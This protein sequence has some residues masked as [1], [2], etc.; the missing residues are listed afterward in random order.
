MGAETLWLSLI[1][2]LREGRSILLL[3]ERTKIYSKQTTHPTMQTL[4]DNQKTPLQNSLTPFFQHAIQFT[5]FNKN[6]LYEASFPNILRKIE[7]IVVFKLLS[8]KKLQKIKYC[9][10]SF[11]FFFLFDQEN[12]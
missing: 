11:S 10:K 1:R 5:K 12:C 3:G 6:V 9:R 2:L 7:F 4:A 8:K